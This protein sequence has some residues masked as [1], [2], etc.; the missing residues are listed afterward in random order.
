VETNRQLCYRPSVQRDDAVSRLKRHEAELKRLGVEHLYMFGS[1]SRGEAEEHS[2]VDLFFDYEKGKL[3]LYELMDVKEAAARIL[4]CKAD[5]MT[6]DSIHK[7][8][9]ERVIAAAV[10]VF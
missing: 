1:T 7:H 3:G 2:D 4:G 8:L 9:R 5:I 10:P 6:R